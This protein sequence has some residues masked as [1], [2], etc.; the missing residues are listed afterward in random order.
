MADEI[1]LLDADPDLARGLSPERAEAARE[2]VRASVATVGRG[3]WDIAEAT[4]RAGGG[5]GLLLVEGLMVRRVTLAHRACAELLG[6]GDLLRPWLE[7]GEHTVMP[8]RA[9]FTVL[10]PLRLAVLDRPATE[11]LL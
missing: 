11:P 7:D 6:S 10:E 2:R 5:F 4:A 3:P 1:L 8:F 9:R